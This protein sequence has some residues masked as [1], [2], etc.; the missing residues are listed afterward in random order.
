MSGGRSTVMRR[1]FRN[2][3][4]VVELAYNVLLGSAAPEAVRVQ[5]RTYADTGYLEQAKLITEAQGHVRVHFAERSFTQPVVKSFPNLA[6]EKHW[7]ATEIA[8]LVRDEQVRLEDILVLFRDAENFKDL[9]GRIRQQQVPGLTGFLRPYHSGGKGDRDRY[10]MS[11]G[12]LTLSTVY[13]AKGYDA[14]VVF[15][16]GA[17]Q[18][19]ATGD[20]NKGRAAFYVAATRA[21]HLLYV[22]GVEQTKPTLL[23]ET[24]GVMKALNQEATSLVKG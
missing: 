2:T 23:D 11:P 14:H 24:F 1:C 13:G 12:Q 19:P 10:I 5:T 6:D 7:V 3:K 20:E 18:F 9:P 16:V 4:E 21:K 8:R 17:D 15:L 22:T